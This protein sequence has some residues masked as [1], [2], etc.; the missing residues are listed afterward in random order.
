MR[1]EGRVGEMLS[2][3]RGEKED[4]GREWYQESVGM[5]PREEGG[6]GIKRV[7]E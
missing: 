5:I 6:S 2:D 4:G 3:G 1:E 7:W